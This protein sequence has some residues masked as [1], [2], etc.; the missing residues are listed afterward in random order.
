MEV[1]VIV[2]LVREMLQQ[3]RAREVVFIR[4]SRENFIENLSVL[5]IERLHT[6]LTEKSRRLEE[7]HSEEVKSL[8]DQINQSKLDL[9]KAVKV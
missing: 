5:Q 2:N 7:E 8:K 1:T 9:D 4:E 3:D 6:D